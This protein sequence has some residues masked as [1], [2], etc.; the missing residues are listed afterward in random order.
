MARGLRQGGPLSPFLFNLVV[1][2]LSMMLFKA[3]ECGLIRGIG[4]GNNDTHITHL[5][6]ADDTMLFIEPSL[7]YLLNAKRILRCFELASGLK[8][9]FHKS[10]L[11]KVDKEIQGE[12]E[13][14]VLMAIAKRPYLGERCPQQ[15]CVYGLGK[16]RWRPWDGG[17]SPC[18]AA[19]QFKGG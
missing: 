13:G 16:Y 4:F 1:E 2:V 14:F 9:F 11:V 15:F 6:F 17:V 10:Y 18:V 8:F 3:K 7:D 19:R 5:Q 12:V